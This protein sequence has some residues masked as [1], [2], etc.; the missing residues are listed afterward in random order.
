M[1]GEIQMK[2]NYN[3]YAIIGTNGYGIVKSWNQVLKCKKYFRSF[4]SKGFFTE[5]S[6]YDWIVETFQNEYN[7]LNH[8][9]CGLDYLKDKGLFFLRKGKVV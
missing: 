4:K 6:A 2:S 1:K 8:E 7:I 3:F 5:Q 9:F